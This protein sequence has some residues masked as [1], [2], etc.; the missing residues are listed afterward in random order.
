VRFYAVI[1]VRGAIIARQAGVAATV[2]ALVRRDTIDEKM[3][4]RQ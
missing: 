4:M 2:K 1:R 3:A